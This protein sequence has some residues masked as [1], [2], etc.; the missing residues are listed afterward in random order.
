LA[1]PAGQVPVALAIFCT[2][3]VWSPEEALLV[4]PI[5]ELVLVEDPA[6]DPVVEP[7][8]A[9]VLALALV[10]PVL[11]GELV[12]LED[13][14]APPTVPMTATDSPTWLVSWAGSARAG[15]TS[16]YATPLL[17][18]TT[19]SGAVPLRQP[20]TTLPLAALNAPPASLAL[21]PDAPLAPVELLPD[22]DAEGALGVVA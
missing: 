13:E 21:L 11:L 15:R 12:A 9:G 5:A 18:V 20:S 22:C 4:L 6:G 3:M 19:K 7:V 10:E 16:L 2:W 8:A 17:S 14:P 1:P